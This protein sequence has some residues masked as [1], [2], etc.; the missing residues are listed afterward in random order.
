MPNHIF[1]CGPFV[2]MVVFLLAVAC[3]GAR[4]SHAQTNLAARA[5]VSFHDETTG[6]DRTTRRLTTTLDLE[7]RNRGVR[8]FIPP[9]HVVV[10]PEAEGVTVHG[11]LGGPE[12]APYN[13]WYLDLAPLLS[14]AGLIPGATVR[15]PLSLSR[16][17]SSPLRYR[18]EVMGVENAPPVARPGGP[19]TAI[20]GQP[21]LLDGSQSSDEEN[22]PLDYVW[23]LGDGTEMSGAQPSHTYALPG[24]YRA[25]L[26]VTDPAQG[27]SEAFAEVLVRGTNTFAL[28]IT[29]TLDA[30]GAMLGDV[31]VLESGPQG[32]V[33]YTSESNTGFLSMGQ[34]GG[35][36]TWRFSRPGHLEVWRE[37][38]LL[39]GQ[40]MAIP[41]PRLA[42]LPLDPIMNVDP[43]AGGQGRVDTVTLSFPAGA[44]S[45]F[46]AARLVPLDGQTLPGP[47]ARGWSPLAA[48]WITLAHEPILAGSLTFT[49]DPAPEPGTS[50]LVADW[51]PDVGRWVGRTVIQTTASPDVTIPVLGQGVVALLRCDVVLPAN[52]TG[53]EVVNPGPPVSSPDASGWTATG[54][55]VPSVMAAS[56]QAGDVTALGIAQF[57][58]PD[59]LVSG[60]ILPVRIQETYALSDGT[61]DEVHP[62][63]ADL[64]AYK[65]PGSVESNVL[66]SHFLTRPNR[67][68]DSLALAAATVEIELLRPASAGAAVLDAQGGVLQDGAVR[69]QFQPGA[70][71]APVAGRLRELPPAGF[72]NVV[73]TFQLDV[74]G[75]QGGA[76]AVALG[77]E[78]QAPSSSFV[79][80]RLIPG[81]LGG[82]QPVERFQSDANGVLS[83][84]ESTSSPQLPGVTGPGVYSL[85]RFAQPVGL[86]SGTVLLEG[87][88][89]AQHLPV[90][91]V[92]KPWATRT[93][94]GAFLLVDEPGATE[95]L[96][97]NP[98]NG[99]EGRGTGTGL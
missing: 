96:A 38:L 30:T 97:V 89:P 91:V 57:V 92:G 60:E 85:F 63:E 54:D 5:G 17:S 59:A 80:A 77:F 24:A 36:H 55:I 81:A 94:A 69:F 93:I 4:I 68:F 41:T 65:H 88:G 58:H 71:P 19:Y 66:T 42:A 23:T 79:L 25:K 11:A 1:R 78:P 29:R 3:G 27:V 70:F 26:R 14:G 40:V 21:L 50:L 61:F 74:P 67:L 46:I 39:P 43:L 52:V 45:E 64:F 22:A 49:L 31:S 47:L 82:W 33:T 15:V 37:G 98:A 20:A 6:M 32:D 99:N 90:R 34:G 87:G 62:Y 13:A 18:I 73:A 51:S 56:D 84:I 35:A 53:V 9:L 16:P 75:W 86:I 28:G 2:G 10:I 83:S 48:A 72:T 7:I 44:F 76:S 95:V 12:V 8:S